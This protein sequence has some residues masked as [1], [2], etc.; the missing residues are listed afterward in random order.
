[1][2][3]VVNEDVPA[4]HGDPNRCPACVTA[5]ELCAE[6]LAVM[7]DQAAGAVLLLSA[8]ESERRMALALMDGLEAWEAGQCSG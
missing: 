2:T 7:R 3:I 4:P 8:M 6:H 5:R 1:M